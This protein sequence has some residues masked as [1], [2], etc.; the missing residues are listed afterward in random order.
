MYLPNHLKNL[1]TYLKVINK[2][3]LLIK[4]PILYRVRSELFVAASL[5]YWLNM[6]IHIQ[7]QIFKK[8][9]VHSK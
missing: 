3:A 8:W 7:L 5:G 2:G 1:Y 4:N 9:P 6:H